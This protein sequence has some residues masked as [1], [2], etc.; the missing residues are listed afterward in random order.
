MFLNLLLT[1]AL[2]VFLYMLVWYLLAQFLR[3]NSIVDIAWGPGFILTWGILLVTFP[4][5]AK[6]Q[7]LFLMILAWGLRLGLHIFIR[8]YRKPEDFRY[9]NWRKEWGRKAPVR[10]FFRVFMLQGSV[11][12]AMSLLFLSVYLADRQHISLV[13]LAGFFLFI[14]GF[15]F[16][17]FADYQLMT[18]QNKRKNTNEILSSGLWRY[19]RH[20]NYFG[21][22]LVWWGLWLFSLNQLFQLAFILIPLGMTLLLRYGSGVPMLEKKYSK[23]EGFREYAENTPVFIP[24]IGKKGLLENKRMK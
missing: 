19:S 11:M 21:E 20:P 8:N 1:S 3:N 22:A 18:F 24:L 5:Y 10:A 16:E 4:S 23:K 13:N 6:S 2:I 12:L 14:T 15:L 17:S 9:A 7:W